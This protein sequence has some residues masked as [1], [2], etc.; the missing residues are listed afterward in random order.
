M[1]R[2]LRHYKLLGIKNNIPFLLGIIQHPSFLEG[3]LHTGFLE[4][5]PVLFEEREMPEGEMAAIAAAVLEKSRNVHAE[6]QPETT[7]RTHGAWK[8][9]S[10]APSWSTEW[11]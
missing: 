5:H 1:R 10:H 11:R 6:Q 9:G 2:A 8:L 7:G 3:K 4:Q